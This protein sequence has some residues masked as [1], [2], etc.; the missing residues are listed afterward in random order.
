MNTSTP[1]NPELLQHILLHTNEAFLVVS[2][3]D[4]LILE[5]NPKACK[6]LSY[7]REE[8][9][10]KP[11]SL[12]ECSLQDIFFWDE[13]VN[14]VNFDGQRII[15]SEWLS[16]NGNVIAIE[17]RVI[18]SQDNNDRKWIIF[19][20]DLTHKQH[21]IQEQ[22]F[23]SSQLQSSLEATA[24][25]IISIDLNGKV[26]NLNQR[27]IKM[28][29]L[30]D[31]LVVARK[32]SDIIE[33]MCN[34]LA[35]PSEFRQALN[36]ISLNAEIE[37][38]SNLALNDD[39]FLI[40]VS[41][42]EYLRDRLIG[43]VFSVRDITAMKEAERNLINTL[44]IAEQA[45]H[46]KS[47]MLDALKVSEAR[48]R[49]LVNSSLIGICQGDESGHITLANDT[50]LNLLG[51][52][53]NDIMNSRVAWMTLA[54]AEYIDCYKNAFEALQLTGHASPF[55]A[56][57]IHKN[58]KKIPVM[59][60]LAQLDGAQFEWV[61]FVLDLSE[62]QKADR[63]K[64]EFISVVSHELRT[65]ITS[66]RGAMS[67]LENGGAGEL[68]PPALK[69][70]QIAHRNSQRLGNLVNDILDMEKLISGK[71]AFKS[72]KF[73]LCLLAEQAIEAN[74]AYASA[75]DVR[76]ELN[77]QTSLR[78]VVGDQDRCMQV[79]A[80]L[81]SNAAKFSPKGNSVSITLSASKQFLRIDVKDNGEGIPM[82]FRDK[83][84]S[85]FSQADGTNTRQQ[86]GTGLG[87]SIAKSMVEKM[88]GE[89]GFDSEIGKGSIF[90]FTLPRQPT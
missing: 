90:W 41:K 45:A 47:R 65:P 59:I 44:A 25:G 85:K 75:L 60:G 24:E 33:Q 58:Q 73:D 89:I 48:L 14:T 35:N 51:V 30:S 82:E 52:S 79:F 54:A 5:I 76:Y 38:E 66:I 40:C 72:E 61:A 64:S 19:A 9:L 88:G 63:V 62:Q 21:I 42:P 50:L 8:L 81:L 27:F 22:L 17:K 55:Q 28:W 36:A 3:P 10:G 77:L 18:C 6:I 13:L 32:E 84:F 26:I 57:L 39:R 1:L 69:L 37:T 78:E 7:K 20:E 86:G 34:L 2:S 68:N 67:I 4:L 46:D 16:Q 80:N 87:L 53:Q 15:E 71:M 11:L 74:T 23:L 83:I 49:R 29:R 56:E 31:E 43:R 70:V 12:I